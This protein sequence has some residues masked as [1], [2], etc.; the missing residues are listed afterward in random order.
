MKQHWLSKPSTYQSISENNN[1]LF[2]YSKLFSHKK[3]GNF[4]LKFRN[5]LLKILL[6]KNKTSY[7]KWIIDE[8]IANA[9]LSS[10]KH[11]TPQWSLLQSVWLLWSHRTSYFLTNVIF[12]IYLHF[13]GSCYS[14]IY[15]VELS[16]PAHTHKTNYDKIDTKERKQLCMGALLYHTCMYICKWSECTCAINFRKTKEG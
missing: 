6:I 4:Q 12:K 11:R 1:I 15:K 13:C 10:P 5:V 7:S 16:Y 8:C 3:T 2:K 9:H 14:N